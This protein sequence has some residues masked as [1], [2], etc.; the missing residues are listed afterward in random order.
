[1]TITA[2]SSVP[3]PDGLN[4]RCSYSE[5]ATSDDGDA[6]FPSYEM[7]VVHPETMA[8][9]E[10]SASE[11]GRAGDKMMMMNGGN[12][13]RELEGDE[14]GGGGEGGGDAVACRDGTGEGGGGT[15]EKLNL[16]P[17][18]GTLIWGWGR[19]QP[20]CLQRFNTAPWMLVTLSALC[21]F[22][23]MV[24]SG[25]T[26]SNATSIERRFK[27]RSQD[28]G[29]LVSIYEATHI[30][31]MLYVA[32]IGGRGHKLKW[33]AI[34]SLI[35]GLASL[36]FALPHFTTDDYENFHD[37]HGD[38]G[39][40]E[41]GGDDVID[42]QCLDGQTGDDLSYYIYVFGAAE[43]LLAMGS[44]P[45][46]TLGVAILDESVTLKNNGI[47][48]GIFYAV[49]TLG[50]AVGYLVAG[51]CLTVFTDI[52]LPEGAELTD[53]DPGWVGAWWIGYVLAGACMLLIAVPL[54]A[55]PR[56]LPTTAKIRSEK[57][58]QAHANAGAEITA[59]PSFGARPGDLLRAIKYLFVNPTFMCITLAGCSDS[60]MITAF[61]VF[62]P[63][64]VENQFATTAT[65]AT[66][67]VGTC[68]VPG[69]VLGV[70]FGG[71]IIRR[72]RLR[73]IGT[74]K[75]C[76]ILTVI[77]TITLPAMFLRCPQ[78]AL[79][80]IL[81]SYEQD[82]FQ[83]DNFIY[84]ESNLTHSCN[85]GCLCSTNQY[86][87]VC[88]EGPDLEFFSPCHAGCTIDYENGTYSNCSCVE[89]VTGGASSTVT[90]GKC[91]SD[92]V[93]IPV[94]VALLIVLL[95]VTF[96]PMVPATHVTLRCVPDSQRPMALGV[97][98]MIGRCLG[99]IPGP[100][101]FGFIIDST[102]LQWQQTCSNQ[103]SCW[104]YHNESFAWRIVIMSC[105]LKVVCG[106]FYAMAWLSYKP[107][108]QSQTNEKDIDYVHAP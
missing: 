86:I 72:F 1:M 79:A 35:M 5:V 61:G 66:T 83:S 85:S 90:A 34:G 91:N 48:I 40:C 47:Y 73:V 25:F 9:M 30:V 70:L 75:L 107:R 27:L 46:Y 88:L 56:E 84:T 68:I 7:E 23:G 64:F 87:P 17:D 58:C 50:P 29:V 38:L 65:V 52:S 19:W 62:L 41:V 101:L 60:L 53:E 33:L 4:D 80:G 37:E 54:G 104:L 15:C 24:N 71:W 36:I 69:G 39:I 76:L 106:F 21:F 18:M 55:F 28:Y 11:D 12:D 57:E 82:D 78:N 105:A 31:F 13:R 89:Y 26:G 108:T 14:E 92:C 97:Q 63:K 6:R 96:M 16:G 74:I 81:V 94:F 20:Q 10:C 32:F 22:Q 2:S 95:V 51:L 49:S 103:G 44:I 45:V 42:E 93:T 102:C 77:T 59:H 98:S 8:T 67:I 100:I 3:K 99:S 43:V